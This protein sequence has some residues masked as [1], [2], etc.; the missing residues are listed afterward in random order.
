MNGSR[1][2]DKSVL[3]E[4][5]RNKFA[6]APVKAEAVEKRD[7]AK[8][9]SVQQNSFRAQYRAELQIALDRIRQKAAEDKGMQFTSLWHHVYN[10]DRLRE[11]YYS[12]KRKASAGVDD[13]TWA[14][15]G[16]DLEMNLKDLSER[17]V[18]GAY[19]A[20][21]VRRVFINKSDG[22]HRP[23]GVPVLEDKIV[24]KSAVWVMNSIYEADFL[25]F[26]YGSR[27]L[28]SAH[29]ALDAVTVGI[30]RKKVSWVLDADI[31]GF[32]DAMNHDWIIKFIEHRIAD[33]RM[34]RHIKKWLNAGVLED[35]VKTRCEEGTPQGGSV[36]P[37]LAN[38]YLHYVFDVWLQQWRRKHARGEVIAVRYVDDIIVG[39]QHRSDAERFLKEMRERFLKFNLELHPVKTRLIEFGRFAK[40][41]RNDRGD[42]KPETFDFLGFTHMCGV[43]R[44]GKFKV[45]RKTIGKRKRAKLAGIKQELKRRMHTPL[46]TQWKWLASVIVGHCRYYGVPGNRKAMDTFRTEV[47]KLWYKIL[48]RRS[49]VDRTTWDR[50]SRLASQYIPKVRTVHPYPSQ[51]L[52]V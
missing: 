31:S 36:S 39:F 10:V 28:R 34:V 5:R 15:Y 1:K 45:Q 25:G 30:E 20:K 13:V 35:G 9:N 38:V 23:L 6:G 47:I 18:R 46:P 16:N 14:G 37:L 7:L 21:P 24:Q 52:R 19:R 33:K 4:K 50:I 48:R 11:A 40:S 29:N 43:T 49:Q 51:R 42:G 22:R 44:K 17:L 32:F 2:S 3:S 26:S 12:L 8:E 27:P 41:N